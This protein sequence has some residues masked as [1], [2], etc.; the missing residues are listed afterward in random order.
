MVKGESTENGT[1]E[2]DK[3]Q[4]DHGDLLSHEEDF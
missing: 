3:G 4:T 2:K 1:V